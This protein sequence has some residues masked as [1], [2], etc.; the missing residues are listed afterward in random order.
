M[1]KFYALSV[2]LLITLAAVTAFAVGPAPLSTNRVPIQTLMPDPAK[3]TC[4]AIPAGRA[5]SVTVNTKGMSSLNWSAFTTADGT[6][7]TVKRSFNS[8]TA[9]MPKSS[10]NW[11]K[12]NQNTNSAVFTGYSAGATRTLCYDAD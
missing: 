4:T 9:Y 3:S 2:V 7:V 1:K 5:A 6:A 10:E 12:I 11:L 8:N